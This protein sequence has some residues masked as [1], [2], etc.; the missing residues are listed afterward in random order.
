MWCDDINEKYRELAA[1]SPWWYHAGG[2]ETITREKTSSRDQRVP[3]QISTTRQADLTIQLLNAFY[4]RPQ[5]FEGGDRGDTAEDADCHWA[6]PWFHPV[7]SPTVRAWMLQNL[8]GSNSANAFVGYL[9]RN[10]LPQILVGPLSTLA[11]RVLT[12]PQGIGVAA[13]NSVFGA[14][15]S[16][17]VVSA[18]CGVVLKT[19][20]LDAI[21][22]PLLW[23]WAYGGYNG[24]A[25]VRTRSSA[26]QALGA[27]AQRNP[28]LVGGAQAARNIATLSESIQNGTPPKTYVEVKERQAF[29]VTAS[30]AAGSIAAAGAPVDPALLNPNAFL[31]PGTPPA[32]AGTPWLPIIGALGAVSLITGVVLLFSSGRKQ[33]VVGWPRARSAA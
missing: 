7:G 21:V 15:P 23:V 11:M 3:G 13:N 25:R 33:R 2:D 18:L 29:A 10:T 30:L 27:I 22:M 8:A 9:Q 32:S 12:A 19:S 16:E 1:G 17:T 24:Q 14:A 5:D 4:K 20:V 6:E 26:V 28:Q 31:P